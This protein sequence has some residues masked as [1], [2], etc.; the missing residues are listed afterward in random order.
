VSTLAGSFGNTGYIDGF[1]TAAEFDDASGLSVDSSGN[2]YV[3]DSANSRIREIVFLGQTSKLHCIFISVTT[4]CKQISVRVD[5]TTGRQPPQTTMTMAFHGAVRSC[6]LGTTNLLS[7][8]ATIFTFAGKGR[9]QPRV[10][11]PVLRV[12]N[13]QFQLN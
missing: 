3:A 4:C 5:I 2:I 10:Q 12:C 9:I 6:Q 8:T 1:G 13:R 11:P 7:L